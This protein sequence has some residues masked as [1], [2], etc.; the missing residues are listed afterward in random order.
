[1]A[2]VAEKVFAGPK[3]LNA[4]LTV[5]EVEDLFFNFCQ[6][7]ES[8]PWQYVAYKG[9]VTQKTASEIADQEATTATCLDCAKIAGVF[10]ELAQRRGLEGKLVHSEGGKWATKKSTDCFDKKVVGNVRI[11][12]SECK[13]ERRCVFN[14]HLFSDFAGKYYDPCLLTKHDGKSIGSWH[15]EWAWGDYYNKAFTIKEDENLVAVASQPG[16]YGFN[17]TFTV[18]PVEK[19]SVEEY[20]LAFHKK[21]HPRPKLISKNTVNLKNLCGIK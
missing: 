11:T 6:F 21:Y 1:M 14:D 20:K 16:Q 9:T 3:K 7:A 8:A 10:I 17:R 18:Y 13:E 2:T 15:F 5:A 12:N 19:I 4:K